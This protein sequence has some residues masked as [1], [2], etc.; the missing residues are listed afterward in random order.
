MLIESNLIGADG[1]ASKFGSVLIW[2]AVAESRFI[3]TATPFWISRCFSVSGNPKRRRRCALP[4]HSKLRHHPCRN[5]VRR[6]VINVVPS[7]LE[8]LGMFFPRPDGRGYL[9]TALR[10]CVGTRRIKG[11][12][13][14]E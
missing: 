14:S 9:M 12:K 10:A 5:E 4:A 13:R 11:S 3:G 2:S 6:I 1:F 7:D 8:S